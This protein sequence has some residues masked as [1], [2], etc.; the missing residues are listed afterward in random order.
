MSVDGT[1]EEL[2]APGRL[3]GHLSEHRWFWLVSGAAVLLR[4]VVAPLW[5]GQDFT[6]WTLATAATLRGVNIYAHHPSYPG[7]PF[8]YVPLFLYLEL[9]LRYLADSTGASFVL[10]GKLPTIAADA[11]I[12]HLLYRRGRHCGWS[13]RRAAWLSAGYLF[14]PLVLYNGAVYGRFDA[15]ACALL[16]AATERVGR[17]GNADPCSRFGL[18]LAVAAK[19]FP[20]FTLPMWLAG[21]RQRERTITITTVLGVVAVLSVPYV[22][23]VGAYVRDIVGYDSGKRPQ[24]STVWVL[25]NDVTSKVTASVVSELGL[26]GFAVGAMFIARRTTD[27]GEELGT[28]ARDSPAGSDLTLGVALTLLAFVAC[29]KVVLEQY[30]MWPLPWLLALI[31]TAPRQQRRACVAIVALLTLVGLGNCES[32]HP[33]GRDVPVAGLLLIAGPVCFS[34]VTLSSPFGGHPRTGVR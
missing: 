3:R 24:G 19:T 6:V 21:Q 14:N 13:P 33:F 11:V 8:A 30:L 1:V 15:L 25:L 29:S 9:P 28:P 12:G 17:Y 27:R 4:L 22:G 31:T 34:K 18:A 26:I 32:F 16:L 2:T 23:S 20:V 7:G 10:L 5:H